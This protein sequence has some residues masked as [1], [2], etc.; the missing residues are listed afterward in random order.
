MKWRDCSPCNSASNEISHINWS[1]FIA[2][3]CRALTVS[4]TTKNQ[5]ERS[6]HLHFKVFPINTL[7]KIISYHS[8]TSPVEILI[9]NGALSRK[10]VK[11]IRMRIYSQELIKS[12]RA[13]FFVKKSLI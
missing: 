5:V 11:I 2:K 1:Y 3:I 7:I 6:S 4:E 10:E 13:V 8:T 12:V 9:I